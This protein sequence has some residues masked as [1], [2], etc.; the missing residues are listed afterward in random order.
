MKSINFPE[1]EEFWSQTRQVYY[2]PST[3]TVDETVVGGYYRTAGNLTFLTVPRS[4]HF[5][6]NNFYA[7]SQQMLV[8]YTNNNA[9]LCHETVKE[10]LCSVTSFM[11]AHMNDCSGQGACSD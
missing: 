9:L 5:V 10:T 8:D 1:S 11:C 3:D 6:P 7:L 4:G 2:I